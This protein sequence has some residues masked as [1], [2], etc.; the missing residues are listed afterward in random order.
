MTGL[1]VCHGSL[2]EDHLLVGALEDV[3]LPP[4]TKCD[5]SFSMLYHA[6]F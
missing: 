2:G 3:S 5:D 1:Q 6:P 4:G